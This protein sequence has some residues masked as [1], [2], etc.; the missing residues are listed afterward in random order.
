MTYTIRNCAGLS[1]GRRK[2]K[3]EWIEKTPWG[4]WRQSPYPNVVR[5]IQKSKFPALVVICR[6]ITTIIAT[7]WLS[8]P[9]A[10]SAQDSGDT[11]SLR[12]SIP[13]STAQH[14]EYL[15][16]ILQQNRNSGRIVPRWT[17]KDDEYL[18]A[19]AIR[20]AIWRKMTSIQLDALFD[21]GVSNEQ[22]EYRGLR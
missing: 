14:I 9:M 16:S 13:T 5:Q 4:F 10:A 19:E 12:A 18:L 11:H 3:K 22:R 6:A 17:P 1:A 8:C 20:D 21:K 2:L 7:F 15:G